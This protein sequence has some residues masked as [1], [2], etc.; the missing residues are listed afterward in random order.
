MV[1]HQTNAILEFIGPA[2]LRDMQEGGKLEADLSQAVAPLRK[3]EGM[4]D[5]YYTF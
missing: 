4:A 3:L 2:R 1:A 5:Y